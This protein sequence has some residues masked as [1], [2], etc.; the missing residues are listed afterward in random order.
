MTF[1]ISAR[2]VDT[3][4]LG[5]AISSSSPAVASRCAHARAGIG[6]VATQNITDP[7]LGPAGLDLMALGASARE[8]RD[9]LV[10]ARPHI[11]YRQ[12]TLID[13]QGRTAFHSG[14]H[15]LGL[16][17]AAEGEGVV[18][19]GNLLAEN[20]IPQIMV[21]AFLGSKGHI[22]NR[23]IGALNAAVAAGGEAG[24]VH[25]AGLL[26]VREVSWPVADLRVDWAD[27]DPVSELAALWTLFEPQLEAYVGRA[28]DPSVAPVFGVP[29]ERQA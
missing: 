16:H 25:S 10:A 2:C 18:A 20:H 12:L 11:D 28:V 23:L 17:A 27:A 15:T 21:D 19:A 5:M 13:A 8:A 29:G 3:G 24:P 22:G 1:S 6:V 4:M 9:I 26:L 7:S 14:R